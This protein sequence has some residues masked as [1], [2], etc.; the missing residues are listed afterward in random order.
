LALSKLLSSKL[1]IKSDT[2]ASNILISPMQRMVQ[3]SIFI[4]ETIHL[5]ESLKQN[6]S[7]NANDRNIIN[8]TIKLLN[9]LASRAKAIALVSNSLLK[10]L[11]EIYVDDPTKRYSIDSIKLMIITKLFASKIVK[12][13]MESD[14]KDQQSFMQMIMQKVNEEFNKNIILSKVENYSLPQSTT[15]LFDIATRIKGMEAQKLINELFALHNSLE[16]GETG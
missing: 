1:Q 2:E 12:S 7:I 15:L 5:F 6:K 16:F 3:L 11:E 14:F 9:D 8:D 13:V 4:N 10:T